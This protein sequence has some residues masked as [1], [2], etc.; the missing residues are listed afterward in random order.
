MVLST[1]CFKARFDLCWHLDVK[2]TRGSTLKRL[3]DLI[4]S[5]TTGA[6]VC[7][8]LKKKGGNRKKSEMA[9]EVISI[10]EDH[11]MARVR[12][13]PQRVLSIDLETNVSRSKAEGVIKTY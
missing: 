11:I 5:L 6:V 12:K 2:S 9:V 1:R 10:E 7:L 13:N 4:G 8:H 3:K